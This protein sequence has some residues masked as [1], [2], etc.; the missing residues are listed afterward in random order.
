MIKLNEMSLGT[1][2]VR[3]GAPCLHP[4]I[5]YRSKKERLQQAPTKHSAL[6]IMQGSCS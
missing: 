2:V 6:Q 5:I 4:M 1:S 3:V